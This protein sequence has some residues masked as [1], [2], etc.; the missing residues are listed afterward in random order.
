M[1][2]K[3]TGSKGSIKQ[4]SSQ[5]QGKAQTKRV[6]DIDDEEDEDEDEDDDDAVVTSSDDD[7]VDADEDGDDGDGDDDDDDVDADDDDDD[8]GFSLDMGG[9]KSKD[10][11]NAPDGPAPGRYHAIVESSEFDRGG[12]GKNPCVTQSFRILN[13][14]C[15]DQSLKGEEYAG[16]TIRNYLYI[17][18]KEGSRKQAMQ[19][20]LAQ[21]LISEKDFGKSN[22]KISW[23]KAVGAHV[24]LTV[25]SEEYQGRVRSRVSYGGCDELF[26]ENNLDVPLDMEALKEDSIQPPRDYV[27]PGTAKKKKKKGKMGDSAI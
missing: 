13:G 16:S 10:D 21:G 4:N 2:D 17:T 25:K 11:L 18:E 9:V 20:A 24:I 5:T 23:G 8:D 27:P 19:F 3:K 1:A 6:D 22:V 7:D 12:E 15:E 26:Q 14:V